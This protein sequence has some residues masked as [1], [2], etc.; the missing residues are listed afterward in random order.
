MSRAPIRSVAVVVVGYNSRALLPDLFDSLPTGLAGLRWH[1]VLADNDS[2][3]D[4][5]A[6]TERLMPTA[7]I[8]RTGGNRGYAAGINAGVAALE[9][10]YDAVL[11]L[12]P[13][14]RLEPGSVA[15]LVS[16]LDRAGVGIAVPRLVDRNGALIHSMRRE[17]TTARVLA[18]T[19]LGARRAGRR[20]LGEVV[21]DP[22]A[23]DTEQDTDWAEGSTQLVSAACWAACGP[24]DESFFLYSEETDFDLRARDAGFRTRY[25]PEAR[26]IHLEGGS[27]PA[28]WAL[29]VVNSVRLHRRR[30][31]RVAAGL[32]WAAVL[33]RESSRALLGRDTSTA[34]VRALVRPSLL[35]RPPGPAFLSAAASR[36]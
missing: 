22:R 1:L 25:V 24:W 10:E 31:G 19:V 3:D 33:L 7:T 13:D 9:E 30:C 36:Q 21:T 6:V 16:A 20:A 27:S 28:L 29:L 2:V 26:A 8:V 18:D 35:R 14:V 15:C 23:Y 12:N 17:P 4:T 11:V 5:V 32:F 34:A